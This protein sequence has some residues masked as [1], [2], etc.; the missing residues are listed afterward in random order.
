MIIEKDFIYFSCDKQTAEKLSAVWNEKRKMWRIPKNLWSIKEII[1]VFPEHHN[2]LISIDLITKG[3]MNDLFIEKRMN[4][5]RGNPK[6]RPYQRVD[7][8][9]LSKIP[10]AAVFNEQRTGKTP[11][12]LSLIEQEGH[13]NVMIVCPA[14]LVYNWEKEVKQWTTLEPIVATGTKK[15]RE[16]IYQ[17]FG[18]NKSIIIS[19]ETLRNDVSTIL[20]QLGSKSAK[21]DIC[22]ILDEAHRLRNHKSKQS[23]ACF[24]LG[25][26]ASKRIALTGTP[27]ANHGSDVWGI[28][29]FLYPDKFPGYW[30]FVERYFNVKD[31][32][33]GKELG[34]YKRKEEL[35]GIL[36]LL[37]VQ[38]KRSEVM[39]WLP[40]KMYQTIELEAD[41]KQLKAYND[42]KDTFIVEQDGELKVDA[43]SVLAQLTRLRQ[44]T[45]DPQLLD[46]EAK[47]AKENFLMEWL[48]DNDEPVIVFSSFTSYLK[49]LS[50]K[51]KGSVM[52]HGELSGKEKQR[53]ADKFQN[54]GSRILLANIISA[55]TG[56]TLDKATAAI[57]LDR[58]YTPVN[59]EQAEDRL[60]P[61]SEERNHSCTIIDLVV[62]DTI[63]EKIHKLLKEKKSIIEV[64]NN[65]GIKSV[66]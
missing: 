35:Q 25:K 52:I 36:S 2:L 5:V 6:L 30:Q 7:V 51:L 57:F 27:S 26:L 49:R 65:Y 43:P 22:V 45:L 42:M 46:I 44:I 59:N 14:S 50:R 47:S 18:K 10:H 56:F 9:Y 21:M 62:K 34:T 39:K 41:K 11:T 38:R 33:F 1:R 12:T 24:S 32:R 16:T 20:S 63:D 66:L 17:K 3:Q 64:V 28:L 23:K 13:Q 29:H 55:G 4:D 40:P 37:S 60:I 15:K 19:Y 54:G 53:A 48:E 8:A 31:G 61:I 58:D